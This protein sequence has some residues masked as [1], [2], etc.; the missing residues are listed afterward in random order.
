MGNGSPPAGQIVVIIKV[1]DRPPSP[2][3]FGGRD[4]G[5]SFLGSGGGADEC[6]LFDQRSLK[7]S[8]DLSDEEDVFEMTKDDR[9]DNETALQLLS[10]LE[11]D[12]LNVALLVP[13]TQEPRGSGW[14]VH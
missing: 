13:E 5:F 7:M 4:L 12:A 2:L 1:I 8:E 14:S 9:F 6:G 10:H 3:P 11:G